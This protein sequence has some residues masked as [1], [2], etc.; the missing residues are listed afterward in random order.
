LGLKL[1]LP[2]KVGL[3]LAALAYFSFAF[4]EMA[5]SSLEDK[6]VAN[7]TFTDLPAALG[8]GFRT[9][10]GF[11][12]VIAI[13][14]YFFKSHFSKQE[15]IMS[16]RLLVVLEAAYW[17][18]LIPSAYVGLRALGYPGFGLSIFI[19]TGLPCVVQVVLMPIVL[20][21]LFYE[22]SPSRPTKNA[23]KWG[24]IAGTSYLLISWLNN[25]GMWI[26]GVIEKGINYVTL[27]PVNAYSFIVTVF[28]LLLLTVY[29]AYFSKKSFKAKSL[30]E[31][32]LRKIGLIIILFGLYM[33]VNYVL[34]LGFGSVGGWGGWYAWM[35]GHNMDQWLLAIPLLGLPLFFHRKDSFDHTQG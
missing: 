7:P 34:W 19:S 33:D 15:A 5:I 29:A 24:L 16:V 31:L 23:I 17:L 28:G 4:Y 20:V 1:D 12:V 22:L 9:V 10:G 35:L 14:L 11:I 8:L 2:A 3:L 27:Y 26:Y 21:K 18:S 13:V 32:N 6:I 30:G 25:M